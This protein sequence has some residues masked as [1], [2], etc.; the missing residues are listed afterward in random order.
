ML[1]NFSILL[2]LCLFR[3]SETNFL[4]LILEEKLNQ[5]LSVQLSPKLYDLDLFIFNL[6]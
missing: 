3:S 5:G 6:L 1:Q 4:Y 2:L